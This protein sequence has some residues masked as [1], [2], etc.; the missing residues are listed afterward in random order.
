MLLILTMLL[1]LLIL[2]MLL[3]LLIFSDASD[4]PEL[5]MLFGAYATNVVVAGMWPGE[6]SCAAGTAPCRSGYLNNSNPRVW[7]YCSL[8]KINPPRGS[9]SLL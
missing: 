3:M 2:T 4:A 5:T 1:M 7:A 6:G 9:E 8:S